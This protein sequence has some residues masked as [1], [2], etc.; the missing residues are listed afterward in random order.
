MDSSGQAHNCRVLL[1]SGSQSHFISQR[2]CKKLAL[3]CHNITTQF[4]VSGIGLAS[5]TIKNG[6][7]ARIKSRLNGFRA[8]V[9]CLV[10]SS[11]TENIPNI[12][13]DPSTLKIPS[14][15]QLADPTYN[16]PGQIDLLLG[17]DLFYHLLSVGQIQLGQ[18]KTILQKTK[19]GW[20]ISGTIDLNHENEARTSC[21]LTTNKGLEHQLA[22]FWTIEE[23]P[24]NIHHSEAE[25]QCE[26]HYVKNT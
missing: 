18:R 7:Q 15:I 22:N 23:L 24:Q 14:N 2:L 9:K 17:A 12:Y 1:D 13:I 3:P 19:L 4:P 21:Y 26:Q 6:T 20:I 11:I 16:T 8:T 5:T 25:I 10:I